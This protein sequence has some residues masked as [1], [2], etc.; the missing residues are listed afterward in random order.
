MIHWLEWQW[1]AAPSA[2]L[3]PLSFPLLPHIHSLISSEYSLLPSLFWSI[4]FSFRSSLMCSVLSSVL[5]P[6]PLYSLLFF[7]FNYVLLI[8]FCNPV[9][10]S[11]TLS[12]LLRTILSP[13][14]SSFPFCFLLYS[15]LCALCCSFY[16][17]L[18]SDLCSLLFVTLLCRLWAFHLCTFSPF[19]DLSVQLL[20]IWRL[21]ATTLVVP[22]S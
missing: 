15:L 19:R 12:L 13:L 16:F 21:T 11:H 17:F 1:A 8:S 9:R 7:L 2:V 22:H 14:V 4:L 5:P 18:P 10:F 6:V 3:F 20:T